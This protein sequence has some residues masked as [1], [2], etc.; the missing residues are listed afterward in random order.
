MKRPFHD[1]PPFLQAS[2]SPAERRVALVVGNGRYAAEKDVLTNP[3]ND[4]R[5]MAEKLTAMG[6]FGVSASGDDFKV[7]FSTAGVPAL[8]DLD[9]KR[10]GKA[11]AALARATDGVRQAVIY[12][13][14][15]GIEVAGENYLIP[16]D[17]GLAHIRDA[18]F[19]TQPLSRVLRTI[20]GA[21]GLRLVI[22]DACRNNPFRARLFGNRDASGGLRGIEPPSNILVAYA[23]KHGMFAADGKAGNNSPFATALLKHVATPGLE[24]LDLF[25]EVKDDVLDATDRAGR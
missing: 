20:E 16:I 6:F 13:A 25:R 3:P 8:I 18:E 2:V 9:Q 19:E 11:L 23:A 4:A 7:D 24:V 5:G 21:T 17:A 12:C 14:G 10:L 22:L 15:H 1:V